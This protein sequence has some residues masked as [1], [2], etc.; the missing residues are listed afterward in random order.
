MHC[1]AESDYVQAVPVP[2]SAEC[3]PRGGVPQLNLVLAYHP[4]PGGRLPVTR[5]HRERH[6]S[7]PRTTFLARRVTS[8]TVSSGPE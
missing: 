7:E 4:M 6:H 1:A 2:Q 3:L 8:A 5:P